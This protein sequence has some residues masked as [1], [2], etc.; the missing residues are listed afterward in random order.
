MSALATAWPAS[1]QS[2]TGSVT[3]L[4]EAPRFR[5][6]GESGDVGSTA[7]RFPMV[8]RAFT[9]RA[10]NGTAVPVVPNG[11]AGVRSQALAEWQGM[12]VEVGSTHFVAELTGKFG[13]GVAGSHEEARLPIDEVRPDDRELLNPGAFFRLCITRE[14]DRGAWKRS[15]YIV[16]RRLP[17]FRRE[18]LEEARQAAR[19][20]VR[21]LRVD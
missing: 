10:G 20:L 9:T 17:A 8:D 12:V 3:G 2:A 14:M 16:F 4:Q 21:G 11:F 5:G 13:A 15:T 6:I 1:P 7:G 18:E 19:D